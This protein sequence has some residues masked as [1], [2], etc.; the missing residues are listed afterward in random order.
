MKIKFSPKGQ[1][2]LELVVAV[3]LAAVV[4]VTLASITTKSISNATAA[5]QKAQAT[6]YVAE[7]IDWV[8]GQRDADW[9]SF[10][11]R[12]DARANNIPG[13]I[14]NSD[15]Y[16][17]STLNWGSAPNNNSA[18]PCAQPI[19]SGGVNTEFTRWIMLDIPVDNQE[20]EI[21]SKVRWTDST[22]QH[23]TQSTVRLTNWR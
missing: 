8:R 17:M 16:C 18:T 11:Q 15:G 23:T 6:R 20:V 22:G 12:I 7:A 1:S 9:T 5:R 4:L 2:L 21:I 13:V 14:G 10:Y 19:Q 3:G